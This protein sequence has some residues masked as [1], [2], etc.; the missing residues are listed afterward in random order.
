MKVLAICCLALGLLFGTFVSG[1]SNPAEKVKDL[2]GKMAILESIFVQ[3]MGEL[4][5]TVQ[6]AKP[7][8][9]A[10]EKILKAKKSGFTWEEKSKINLAAYYEQRIEY[11]KV[12]IKLI[13]LESTITAKEIEILKKQKEA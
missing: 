7:I 5:Q 2:E 11:L 12:L 4:Q 8:F 10:A 1:F 6:D 13:I 3:T 9:A